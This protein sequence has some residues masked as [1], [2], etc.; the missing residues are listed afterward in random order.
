MVKFHAFLT[1]HMMHVYGYLH[2]LAD[3]TQNKDSSTW[4]VEIWVGPKQCS[5][6]SGE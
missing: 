6:P 4:Y 1:L 2:I 5:E 3:I